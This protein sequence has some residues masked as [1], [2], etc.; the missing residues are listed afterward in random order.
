MERG[1]YE[2][3]FPGPGGHK[4]LIAVDSGGR[5][6]A[7]ADL[8]PGAYRATVANRLRALLDAVDDG[9]AHRPRLRKL[10]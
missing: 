2:T 5:V 4:R 3:R 1:L 7:H 8:M 9:E 10:D 6:V